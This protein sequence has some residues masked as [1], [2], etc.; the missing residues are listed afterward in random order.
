[1][2][3]CSEFREHAVRE[4]WKRCA[5]DGCGRGSGVRGESWRGR[6]FGEV[7]GGRRI[8]LERSNGKGRR[9][10]SCLRE[11]GVCVRRVTCWVSS[12]WSRDGEI[13]REV[14]DVGDE[15]RRCFDDTRIGDAEVTVDIVKK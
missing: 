4:E 8:Q 6:V 14:T 12:W 10:P 5:V 13:S 9:I 2:Y 1:M 11:G 15:C 7:G 3:T